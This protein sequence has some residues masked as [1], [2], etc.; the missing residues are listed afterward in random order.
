M[1]IE[2]TIAVAMTV[3]GSD[4][5]GGA[6]V[7]AD[8]KTFAACRVYG[9]SAITTIIA[10]NSARV[11]RL[12]PVEPAMVAAQIATLVEERRPDA[13]KTGALGTAGNVKAIAAAIRE[14]SLPAPVVDPVMLSSSGRRLLDVAGEKSLMADLIPLARVVTPNLSEAEALSGITI[15]GP[16]AMRAAARAIRKL[17]ARAVVIKGGHSFTGSTAV[18]GAPATDLFFDGRAFVE[19][20]SARIPGDGAHGTGCA[21]SAAIAAYLARG[22]S[23]ESAIRQAKRF[24]TRA[25]RGRILLGTGR[26]MLDHFLRR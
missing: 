18:S 19:L 6:G 1:A 15:N 7:Q 5:A 3:A 14:L 22:E 11:E 20:S 25:L 4:P 17:G 24:V 12:A 26:P 9:F 2:D 13:L 8:L 10:Q 23:L 16:A 21:F